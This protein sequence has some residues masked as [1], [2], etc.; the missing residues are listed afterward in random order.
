MNHLPILPLLEAVRPPPCWRT[1]RAILST[2]SADPTVLIALLLALGGRDDDSGSGNRVEL[3]RSFVDL[4]GKV[5]FLLQRGRLSA[6]RKI[7]NVLS[8]LDRF[9]REVAWNEKDIFDQRGRSWHAKLALV[10]FVPTEGVEVHSPQ[11]RLWLGSRNFTRD[12]SWDIGL[13][14]DTLESNAKRGRT[15]PGIGKVALR[16]AE[17]AG[18]L[19]LWKPLAT[20]LTDI[21][22][23]VPAGLN[24]TKVELM[25]PEDALRNFPRSPSG[26]RKVVAVAPFL[27]GG[28]ISTLSK[29]TNK[30][31]TLISTISELGKLSDQSVNPLD[32]FDL[33]AFPASTQEMESQPEEVDS[34]SDAF[35]EMQG[36]HAKLIWAE[37]SGGTTLWLGSPNLTQRAWHRNAEA[38]VEVDVQKRGGAKAAN[39]VYEGIDTFRKMARPVTS[40]ELEHE[41]P[42]EDDQEILET[43]RQ[44]VAARLHGY[45]RHV[46]TEFTTVETFEM[47]P[48]PDDACVVLSVGR[49]GGTLQDW[50]RGKKL[51]S[52]GKND[53][54]ECSD[55][56]SVRVTLRNNSISWTQL[57]PFDPPLTEIR[58]D[59]A[60]LTKF[61]GTRG[62]LKW[63]RD[64]L[65][66]SMESDGGGRWDG[67]RKRSTTD[68][69][70]LRST[71]ADAPTVE[72]VLRAWLR[73]PNRLYAV[74]HILR[75]VKNNPE[76]ID[77]DVEAQ[78]QLK[79]FLRSWKTIKAGLISGGRRVD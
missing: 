71:I 30:S 29:W 43:A 68:G 34:P 49:L 14:I 31:R 42:G 19:A 17:Y 53:I 67:E 32:G 23:S 25:L 22:W 8:L 45:Q 6:P 78:M 72:K 69:Q 26:V 11:W 73:N 28:T 52:L 48:H 60:I 39:L 1:D 65:D 3:A 9:L 35:S 36:L 54:A 4:K 20:E 66:D 24:L 16:L 51:L 79:A 27:D 38:F 7:P 47:P 18:E 10:R 46:N 55:L 12:T 77:D 33:L 63:L 76:H 62:T 57:V 40:E 59:T 56:V 5:T 15:L 50:P 74:D 44:E 2:Y 61:L 58:D 37:H 75:S 70:P 41:E 13:S 21:K 64:V